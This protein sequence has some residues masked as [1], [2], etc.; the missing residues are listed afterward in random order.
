MSKVLN[1][2][3]VSINKIPKTIT[4]EVTSNHVHPLYG[5]VIKKHKNI[6]VHSEEEVQVGEQVKIVETKPISKNKHFR[7][8]TKGKKI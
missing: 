7:V 4:V 2:K 8:L 6:L 5:K 1:G 3:V